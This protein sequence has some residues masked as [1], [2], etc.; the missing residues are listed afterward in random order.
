MAIVINN[1]GKQK[2]LEYFSGKT[3][4]T[5]SIIL[6]LYS[7]NIAPAVDNA[8]TAYTELTST[9]GYTSKTLTASNWTI[10]AGTATYPTQTWTFTAAAGSVYGYY[11]VGAT[12]GAIL[13]A[14]KF[15]GGPYTVTTNGDS[16]SV[17]INITLL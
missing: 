13:F 10:S 5:E 8:V 3:T 7:N 9:G 11:A 15:S 1:V 6:K 16:I 2:A 4:T 12:S 14:E 17:V